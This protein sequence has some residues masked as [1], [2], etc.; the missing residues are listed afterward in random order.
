MSFFPDEARTSS[1]NPPAA[2]IVNRAG[3]WNRFPLRMLASVGSFACTRWD[4][5]RHAAA[6]IATVFLGAVRPRSW[7]ADFRKALALQVLTAGVGPV[8]FVCAL[9]AVVGILV[10]VQ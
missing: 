2:N 1:M 9:A 4:N 8:G 10:V 3:P 7:T 6:V 5:L